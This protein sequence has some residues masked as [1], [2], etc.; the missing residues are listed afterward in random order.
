MPFGSSTSV[1]LSPS[2]LMMLW[3]GIGGNNFARKSPPLVLRLRVSSARRR[4]SSIGGG[5]GGSWS[6][7]NDGS[8]GSSSSSQGLLVPDLITSTHS[9]TIK[10]L[11]VLLNRRKRRD[12]LGE[13]VAE[14]PRLVLDLIRNAHTRRLVRQVVVSEAKWDAYAPMLREAASAV[15]AATAASSP[16]DVGRDDHVG[17]PSSDAPFDLPF[18]LMRA[19]CEVMDSCTDTVTNQG[20]VARVR[21]PTYSD[22]E[23]A[24]VVAR[25]HGGPRASPLYVVLDGL[26]DPGN[27]GTLVRSCVAVGAAQMLLLPGSADVWSPKALRSAMGTTFLLPIRSVAS[28]DECMETL[29][30]AGCQNMYAA[31]MQDDESAESAS[32][33]PKEVR[34]S[35][36]H[37]GVDWTVGPT[38]L[39]IGSE[40]SGLSRE[41]RQALLKDPDR[42]RAVH[43]PMLA[44][45]E[46]LN[47]AVCGSVIL[48][49]YLRQLQ[50]SAEA[51]ASTAPKSIQEKR[52]D[53]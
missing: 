17:D 30:V 29:R 6:T 19:T 48:F 15:S 5:S 26:Q 51:A 22:D 7:N 27:V 24:A 33:A 13:A 32:K 28:L 43:V 20:I 16:G 45:V 2:L 39:V 46:S 21:I 25:A 11:S 44:G 38:A 36:P 23:A 8:S 9:K 42:V 34:P 35:V 12:E 40:G 37:Y 41:V 50:Q 49:E 14:G 47:A 52:I 18:Q 10:T 31:T 53:Q 4:S 3:I 1:L